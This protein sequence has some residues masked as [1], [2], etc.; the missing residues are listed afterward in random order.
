[1]ARLRG[2]SLKRWTLTGLCWS[3]IDPILT[4]LLSRLNFLQENTLTTTHA[5]AKRTVNAD[6]DSTVEFLPTASIFNALA[7]GCVT[8]GSFSQIAGELGIMSQGASLQLGH[9]CFVGVGTRIWAKQSIVIGDYVLIAHL[10]DIHDS[11]GH[12]L[13]QNLRRNDPINLFEKHIE[14][15]WT[16]VPSCAVRIESDVWIGFKSS[17]MKGVTIGQGAVV[18]AGSVVTKD[19]PAHTLVAGNPAQVIRKLIK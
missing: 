19:V 9:H 13:D 1:M 4:K 18:A 15:D 2:G 14:R 6:C 16:T 11:D 10:V 7:P 17:I 5:H 8:I 12:T 3:L